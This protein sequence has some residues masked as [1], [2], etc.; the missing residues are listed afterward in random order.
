VGLREGGATA[1]VSDAES[2]E[3]GVEG[4][5]CPWVV[6]RDQAAANEM[7]TTTTMETMQPA[8]SAAAWGLLDRIPGTLSLY[9][10]AAWG[11]GEFQCTLQSG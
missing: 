2:C 3:G 11:P 1:Q 4:R 9:G 8:A 5:G 6:V 10:T 7:R